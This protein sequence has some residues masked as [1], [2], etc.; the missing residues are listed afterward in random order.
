MP[1]VRAAAAMSTVACQCCLRKLPAT[2]VV[3]AS[4]D[5]ACAICEAATARKPDRCFT[6]SGAHARAY[7]SGDGGGGGQAADY[8][9]TFVKRSGKDV[10]TN[11]AKIKRR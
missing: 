10:G 9:W 6:C 1:A 11:Y 8:D 7:A 2:E 4:S 5:G 3:Y